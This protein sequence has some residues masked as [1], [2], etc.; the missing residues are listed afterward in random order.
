MKYKE[1]MPKIL[2]YISEGMNQKE[3]FEK[4]GVVA[5]TFY[6]WMAENSDF[7]DAVHKAQDDARNNRRTIEEVEAALIDRARGFEREEVRTEYISKQNEE[8]KYVPVVSKQNRT[9]KHYVPDV[10]AIKFYLTNRDPERW[11][12]RVEQNTTAQLNNEIKIRYVGMDG[13]DIHFPS[14]EDEVDLTRKNKEL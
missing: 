3:A 1:V 5:S 12:N 14:S 11:K 8:G 10:E 9:T 2:G 4:A 6:K 13:E 7:S